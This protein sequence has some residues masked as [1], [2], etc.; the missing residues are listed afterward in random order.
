MDPI[1]PIVS[2]L[3]YWSMILCSFGGQGIL[4]YV[5]LTWT[6]PPIGALSA[7]FRVLAR[8]ELRR[9]AEQP[10]A[11]FSSPQQLVAQVIK[12]WP[13]LRGQGKIWGP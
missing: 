5:V 2:I 11:A 10:P 1:L 7:H 8:F 9:D 6:P 3:G 4:Q 12:A 13:G